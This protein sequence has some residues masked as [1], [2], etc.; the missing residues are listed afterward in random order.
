MAR[1]NCIVTDSGGYFDRD[2]KRVYSHDGYIIADLFSL[3][4]NEISEDSLITIIVVL[5]IAYHQGYEVAQ[6]KFAKK[7]QEVFGL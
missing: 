3:D 6:K 7:I 4:I 2:T 1:K 5:E